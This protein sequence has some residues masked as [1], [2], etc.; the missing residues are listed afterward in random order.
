MWIAYVVTSEDR[1]VDGSFEKFLN[2]VTLQEEDLRIVVGLRG[3]SL[4]EKLSKKV[5]LSIALPL[6]T[7]LSKARNELIYAYPYGPNDLVC[8]PD[9]DCWYPKGLLEK[10]EGYVSS[11]DFILGVIDTGQKELPPPRDSWQSVSVKLDVALKHSASAALFVSGNKMKD[12][13]FDQR[14]GLGAKVGSA[15][16]LDLV[17][18][19]IRESAVGFY[20]DDLRVFHPYK[21]QR[22]GEYFEG[23]I[24]ALSKYFGKIPLARYS[25]F[26]RLIKGLLLAVAGKLPL[27]QVVNGFSFFRGNW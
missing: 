23:S 5:T 18:F 9:D 26:R 15:E 24:A 10:I 19:L 8:F 2:S 16:D 25:A 17:L 20:F 12:F 4:P 27:R 1:I 11:A 22:D 21:P 7:S 3:C 13:K 6:Q 14:L